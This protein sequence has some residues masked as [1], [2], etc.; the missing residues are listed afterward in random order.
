MILA[1]LIAASR[2]MHYDAIADTADAVLGGS[3]PERRLEIMEDSAIGAFGAT[4]VAF[5]IAAQ[6][7][8]LTGIVETVAWYA[9][10]IGAVLAR[11]GAAL[12]FWSIEPAREHGLAAPLAGRPRA[13]TVVVALLFVAALAALPFVVVG[14][15]WTSI[16]LVTS[17]FAGWPAHQVQGFWAC[18]ITGAVS[19]LAFPWLLSRTVRGITGDIVGASIAATMMMVLIAG[20]LF[21]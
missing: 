12:A 4:A 2:A 1:V 9:I 15:K 10:I 14:E 5:I 6:G 11:F 18:L 21:G 7:A 20:A 19:M 16:T 3:T 17:A 13:G 8:A